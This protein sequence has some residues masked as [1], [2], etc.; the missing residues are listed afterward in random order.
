MGSQSGGSTNQTTTQTP[1]PVTQ[2][3]RQDV[4]NRGTQQIDQG[5]PA[6]YPGQTVATP[7]SATTGSLSDQLSIA[8]G[9]VP[10]L[11]AA[12]SAN[13]R[14]LSGWNPA[15][16]PAA[17][18]ANGGANTSGFASALLSPYMSATNSYLDQ[19][20]QQGASDVTDAV[21]A[22]M[23]K[24]GR[25]GANA[26]TAGGLSKGIGNLYSSI[27]MPAYESNMNRGL[28]AAQTLNGDL[29]SDADRRLSA[30]GTLGNIYS[31]GN[32]DAA[33]ATGQLSTIYGDSLMPA[34]TEQA[35]GSIYDQQNQAQIDA[36]VAK[37]DYTANAPWT[38]L[39]QFSAMM[40][41]LPTFGT[42]NTTGSSEQSKTGLSLGF[43]PNGLSFGIG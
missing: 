2:A 41:G 38:Q 23:A 1:D 7:S 21:N 39:Q 36:N 4:F 27:Y 34:L 26:A 12:Q 37:Y 16:M 32:A 29:T 22:E 6:Y 15:L 24:A 13:S 25:F 43:G 10:N 8:N 20:F 42:T 31:Q 17:S 19:T 5:P 18:I 3:W 30:T 40:A 33:T 11:G 35:V 9:G 28:S 14:M